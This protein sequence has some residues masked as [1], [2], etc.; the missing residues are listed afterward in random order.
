MRLGL[1]AFIWAFP[2]F[3][4]I[5]IQCEAVSSV[6]SVHMSTSWLGTT[7]VWPRLI[8]RMSRNAKHSG[9]S[10]SMCPGISLERIRVKTDGINA[11]FSII[12]SLVKH[13]HT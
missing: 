3:C 11:S 12:V 1:K 10:Q 9:S 2:I 4:A 7:R 5:F 8:G 6:R 13:G